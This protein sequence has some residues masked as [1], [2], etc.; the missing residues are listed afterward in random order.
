MADK[1]VRFALSSARNVPQNPS[2][3]HSRVGFG[4]IQ[5]GSNYIQI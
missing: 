1:V 2:G 3:Y 4:Q 5:R